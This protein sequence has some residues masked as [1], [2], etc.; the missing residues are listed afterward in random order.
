MSHNPQPRTGADAPLPRQ[1]D[2]QLTND[3]KA[4]HAASNELLRTV[5]ALGYPTASQFA[6]RLA[7][8]EAILNGLKHGHKDKPD[9]PVRVEWEA[10]ESRIRMRV[11][12]EGPGFDPH[13][14]PDPTDPDR[15][16]LPSGRGLL[17]MR[18]YMTS[19]DYNET[20]NRVEM[21]YEK[22]AG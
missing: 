7:F 9:T 12:D 16:E 15:I 19:V 3:P 6:V 2:L 21:V 11:T 17:L 14:V 10:D 5:E 4:I 13:G 8:E 20:G 1:R 18:A 22:P